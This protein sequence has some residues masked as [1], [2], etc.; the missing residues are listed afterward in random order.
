V[1][2][3]MRANADQL[4]DSAGRA[5]RQAM[6]MMGAAASGALVISVSC[7]GRRMVLGERT[8]EEAET[9]AESAPA[10]AV[11]AGFYSYGEIAPAAAGRRSELHNQTMTVTVLGEA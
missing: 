4:I 5:A 1:A 3:L 8:E 10:G 2:R 7:V 9:V 6:D 11:H